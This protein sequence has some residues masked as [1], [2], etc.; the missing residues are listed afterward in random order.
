MSFLG[1]APA[2]SRPTRRILKAIAHIAAGLGVE[3]PAFGF[4]HRPFKF[5]GGFDPLLNDHF[6]ICERLLV[7]L[8]VGGAAGQLWHFGDVGLVFLA[9]VDDNL[10]FPLT[11]HDLLRT[12]DILRS[13]LALALPGMVLLCFLVAE[14]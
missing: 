11:L 8:S 9:P 12:V 10:V 7:C 5:L 13:H 1:S 4:R 3:E 6:H 2:V 14:D